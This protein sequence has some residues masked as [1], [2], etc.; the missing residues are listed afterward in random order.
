M[1]AD[2]FSRNTLSTVAD[3]VESTVR[4]FGT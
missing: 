2:C 1:S 4:Q 3:A